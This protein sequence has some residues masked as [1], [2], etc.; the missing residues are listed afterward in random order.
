MAKLAE[1]GFGFLMSD[2]STK[3][4]QVDEDGRLYFDGKPVEIKNKVSLTWWVNIA[5]ILAAAGALAQGTMAV[6]AYFWPH[7]G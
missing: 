1:G 2:G 4:L 3:K 5:A 7:H 6:I